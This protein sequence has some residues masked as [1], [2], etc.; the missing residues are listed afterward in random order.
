MLFG[1]TQESRWQQDFGLMED[2]V[3]THVRTLRQKIDADGCTSVTTVGDPGYKTERRQESAIDKRSNFS[4][5]LHLV[6][7]LRS[8][9]V[10]LVIRQL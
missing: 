4:F 2:T 9:A 3:R 10:R 1:E 8:N 7:T 5:F 6:F